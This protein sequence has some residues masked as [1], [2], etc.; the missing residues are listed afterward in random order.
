MSL[1]NSYCSYKI[2]YY[3]YLCVVDLLYTCCHAFVPE[4]I[5]PSPVNLVSAPDPF[6]CARAKKGEGEGGKGLATRLSLA[7]K[8][9]MQ[10]I[11]ICGFA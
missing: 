1:L 5:V 3:T 4:K 10:K 2:M 8:I 7:R 9:G 11:L 6:L